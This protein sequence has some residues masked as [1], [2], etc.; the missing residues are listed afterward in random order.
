MM[1]RLY[2]VRHGQTEWN[3][4]KK[5]QGWEDSALTEKGVNNAIAL[6]K[7]LEGVEFAAAY[8]STS[9]RTIETARLII[10]KRNLAINTNEDLREIN[11]GEW[12]G[13]TL[14]EIKDF[15]PE[16]FKYFWENPALYEPVG[17]ETFEQLINRAIK[18]LNY[19]TSKHNNGNILVITHS[20]IL[21]SLLMHVNGKSVK[22]LWTPPFIHDT[23]LSI[24]EIENEVY[25]VKSEGDISHL[26]SVNEV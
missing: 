2:L 6:R 3:V 19:I 13:K 21:K 11:L 9:E 23:S 14:D 12:E 17:G 7:K 15:Y 1:L 10:E 22:D 26:D 5:M 24:V 16:Q 8:T 4:Q 20:V 18:V 25:R